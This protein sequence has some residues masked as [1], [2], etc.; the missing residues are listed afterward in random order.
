MNR[1][2][3]D[4][5]WKIGFSEIPDFEPNLDCLI[6]DGRSKLSDLLSSAILYPKGLFVSRTFR[7]VFEQYKLPPHKFFP[8]QIEKNGTKSE[9]CFLYMLSDCSS[10]ILFGESTFLVQ[11]IFSGEILDA[12]HIDSKEELKDSSKLLRN[13]FGTNLDALDYQIKPSCL[14]FKDSFVKK[15]WDVF[16]FSAIGLNYYVTQPLQ[17]RMVEANLTGIELG[18]ADL[19]CCN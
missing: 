5:Y 14:K 9:Y 1:Y 6:V 7:E 19:L 3:E 17:E 12:I 18:I 8:A 16:S 10:D 11:N 15:A 4:S 2:S 13:R